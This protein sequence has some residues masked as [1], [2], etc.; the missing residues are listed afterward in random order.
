M[1]HSP[2]GGESVGLS[3]LHGSNGSGCIADRNQGPAKDGKKSVWS[4]LRRSR[5]IPKEKGGRAGRV[6]QDL[7]D[8][9]NLD[10]RDDGRKR[11]RDRCYH[12]SAGSHPAGFIR[13]TVRCSISFRRF[14]NKQ[15]KEKGASDRRMKG[16][17]KQM[18]R[19]TCI[20]QLGDFFAWRWD[21]SFFRT[22]SHLFL[23]ALRRFSLI[24]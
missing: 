3:V 24:S 23:A 10:K 1:G 20:D 18:E 21:A 16:R 2:F 6:S 17:T 8:G 11:E 14:P 15:R 13:R 12:E 5:V 22:S 9:K 19:D 4:S 7:E